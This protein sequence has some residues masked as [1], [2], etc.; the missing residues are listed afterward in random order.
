MLPVRPEGGL[1][2]HPAA[3]YAFYVENRQIISNGGRHFVFLRDL[4][5]FLALLLI[6]FRLTW[7]LQTTK[8]REKGLEL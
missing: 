4:L 1:S 2:D 7:S 6:L 5:Y 3:T 8:R